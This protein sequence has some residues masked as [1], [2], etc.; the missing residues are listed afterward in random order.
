MDLILKFKRTRYSLE[1]II[2]IA[3][4]DDVEMKQCLALNIMVHFHLK[5]KLKDKLQ[6]I[7]WTKVNYELFLNLSEHYY[8]C[9]PN[10]DSKTILPVGCDGR[11]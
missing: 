8:F 2:D 3:C 1:S 11:V 9:I 10:D 4:P 7:L 5:L 6:T